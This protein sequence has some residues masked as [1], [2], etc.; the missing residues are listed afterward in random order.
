[1]P[2]LALLN[3]TYIGLLTRMFRNFIDCMENLGVTCCFS[4]PLAALLLLMISH[5]AL[6]G[7]PRSLCAC[8][9]ETLIDVGGLSSCLRISLV[10]LNNCGIEAEIFFLLS[11][12]GQVRIV[13][14]VS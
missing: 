2:L 5:A 12:Y 3:G 1:M 13:K 9:H 6:V 4:C 8:A 11:P 10:T 14:P 7:K